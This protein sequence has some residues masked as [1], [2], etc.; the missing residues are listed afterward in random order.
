MESSARATE[1]LI[2][3]GSE[4]NSLLCESMPTD[5]QSFHLKYFIMSTYFTPD[6][7]AEGPQKSILQKPIEGLPPYAFDQLDGSHKKALEVERVY[8]YVLR[9]ADQS[10]MGIFLLR[11]LK[12][13]L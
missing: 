11:R 12:T 8:Y 10:V 2:A 6:L 4:I 7:K 3:V 1:S 5:D 9:K 13:P